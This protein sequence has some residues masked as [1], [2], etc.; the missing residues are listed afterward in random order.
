MKA[1]N[2]TR[3][4]T[5][6]AI[7]LVTFLLFPILMN[8]LSP[9]V[10]IDGASQGILNGSAVVFAAMF[11][12]ALFVGRLYCGWLCPVGGLMEMTFPIN[13]KPVNGRRIDCIKWLIWGA[14]LAVI[15]WMLVQA[16][17]YHSVN[18][19]LDTQGGISL[20]G[21]PDRPIFIAYIIYYFVLALM[22][23]PGLIL[24][25]RAAC[26]SLCW[27]APFMIL[28][29]KLRNTLAWPALR[30]QAEPA[31]CT[32]CKTCTTNCPMSLDV[33]AMV[34]QNAMEH[35]ECILCG[36]CVDGCPAKAIRYRFSGGK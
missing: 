5:R 2:S 24:G 15:L 32:N 28:G 4:R 34:K 22:I 30:L 18:L 12:S 35:A 26:H 27:M 36:S 8:Y 17:G 1:M 11:V 31:A 19:G 13:N 16:G 20:A 10:I 29:R 25:R 23:V 6:K 14:W 21:S 9:Y 3:Q 33:N 7:L